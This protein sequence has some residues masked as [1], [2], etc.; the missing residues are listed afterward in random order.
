MRFL[1]FDRIKEV[2]RGERIVGVKT[3]PLS[4]A[5]LNAHFSR[6]PR[7]P[8]SVLIEA[9]AQITGWLV[10]YTHDFRTSCVISLIDDAEVTSDLRPGVTVEI[11]G[12]IIDTNERAS[13]CR[14][15]IEKDGVPV[16]RAERFVYPHFPNDDPDGLRKRFRNYGWLAFEETA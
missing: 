4:E 3:F 14:A 13:L 5:Y 2:V 11:H 12:E 9:M 1:F 8:G 10:V 6:A 7:V 15:R 16:A